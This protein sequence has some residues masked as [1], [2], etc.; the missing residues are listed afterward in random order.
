MLAVTMGS[1]VTHRIAGK[2][3]TESLSHTENAKTSTCHGCMLRC[4]KL[5][6]KDSRAERRNAAMKRWFMFQKM[7]ASMANTPY[8]LEKEMSSFI[9]ETPGDGN[10]RISVC[11]SS[12]QI[13]STAFTISWNPESGLIYGMLGALFVKFGLTPMATWKTWC[14]GRKGL[15]VW[16]SKSHHPWFALFLQDFSIKVKLLLGRTMS[17]NF[18][19]FSLASRARVV[20]GAGST[21][22]RFKGRMYNKVWNEDQWNKLLETKNLLFFNFHQACNKSL[23]REQKSLETIRVSQ[24]LN[25]GVLLVS[26]DVNDIDAGLYEGMVLF[27]ENMWLDYANWSFHLRELFNSSEK[28]SAYSARAYDLF[29]M[30]FSPRQI[31]DDAKV[32]DGGYSATCGKT[33]C[34][35]SKDRDKKTPQAVV[36]LFFFGGGISVKTKTWKK[37]QD[38]SSWHFIKG[39]PLKGMVKK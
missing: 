37:K 38:A 17:P 4:E 19:G 15:A 29:K 33:D 9:S 34:C 14:S 10:L 28:L 6:F 3:F 39:P 30:R 2:T 22:R 11:R 21:L 24:S 13:T 1:A 31:M 36:D 32:W 35:A 26:E 25:S 8:I 12:L 20:L 16:L 23:P 7:R 27:E 5:F 18:L